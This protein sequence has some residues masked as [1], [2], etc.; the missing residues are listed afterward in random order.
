LSTRPWQERG[1]TSYHQCGR[2]RQ[3]NRLLPIR[4]TSYPTCRPQSISISSCSRFRTK[5]WMTLTLSWRCSSTPETNL[6]QS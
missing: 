4:L 6:R 5:S 2:F 3:D 1:R